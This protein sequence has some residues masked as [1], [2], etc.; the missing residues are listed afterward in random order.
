M[1]LLT[2][3][4]NACVKMQSSILVIIA[5]SH[6][7]KLFIGTIQCEQVSV[8]IVF[9]LTGLIPDHSYFQLLRD[10]LLSLQSL[11]SNKTT[12]TVTTQDGLA[13]CSLFSRFIEN[14]LV[15]FSF[16][17]PVVFFI[18]LHDIR[19]AESYSYYWVDVKI[20]LHFLSSNWQQMSLLLI[21]TESDSWLMV[22]YLKLRT[23]E[24]VLMRLIAVFWIIIR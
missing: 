19:N 15:F 22:C 11:K 18:C 16:N 12:V 4:L 9:C 17:K 5:S 2:Y 14:M 21:L 1:F 3:K 6:S 24:R 20:L 7:C 13:I 10:L 23:S 8:H